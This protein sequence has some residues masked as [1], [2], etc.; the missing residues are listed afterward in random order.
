MPNSHT[1]LIAGAGQLG[2]RYLQG[3]ASCKIPMRILV[4]DLSEESLLRAKHRWMEVND[5]DSPH[6]VSFETSLDRLPS[7]VDVCIVATTADVRPAVFKDI[8]RRGRVRY[9]ILEK[10]LAQNVDGLDEF[11]SVVD[12]AEGTWVNM[13]RRVIPWHQEIRQAIG[14]SKKLHVELHA[15]FWGLAC[16]GIHLIDHVT[17]LSGEMIQSIDAS[18]L[19]PAWVDSKRAGFQEVTGTLEAIYS[20]GTTLSLSATQ[21]KLPSEYSVRYKVMVDQNGDQWTIS[22][23]EGVASCSDGRRVEGRMEF[24]SELTG[25]LVECILATGDCEL[26]TFEESA[27]M[28]RL[29]LEALLMHRRANEDPRAKILPIT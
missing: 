7:E 10:L 15:G 6:D 23:R 4:W 25:R 26:T 20:A 12:E 19:D 24:Q 27:E 17:W 8:A 16:N 2:S 28:H 22:E 13:V 11:R 3:L 21:D 29:L 5:R 14:V 18:Q 1:V 9:W